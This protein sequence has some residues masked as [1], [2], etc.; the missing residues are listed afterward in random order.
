MHACRD[1]SHAGYSHLITSRRRHTRS[2]CDWSSDVCSSDLRSAVG[3]ILRST[4]FLTL[5]RGAAGTGKSFALREVL[6]G[7]ERAGHTVHVIAP[8]RQQVIDLERSESV[9]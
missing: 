7:L 1:I 2:L 3:L 6:R 5:F 9:V 4:D 8:Q